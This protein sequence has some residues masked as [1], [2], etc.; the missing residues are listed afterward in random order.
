MAASLAATEAAA[1][2][3]QHKIAEASYYSDVIEAFEQA[4]AAADRGDA[5]DAAELYRKA[6]F[7]AIA[8]T[9]A[10]SAVEAI[11]D[12]PLPAGLADSSCTRFAHYH[13]QTSCHFHSTRPACQPINGSSR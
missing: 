10:T 3:E 7:H 1:N 2:A 13:P 6:T 5:A 8:A 12:Y 9:N 11:A 4:A